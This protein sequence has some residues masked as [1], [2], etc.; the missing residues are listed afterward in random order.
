M[1]RPLAQTTRV[2]KIPGKRSGLF[3]KPAM[4]ELARQLQDALEIS[5]N[6]GGQV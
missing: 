6:Q 1:M 2:V 4:D 5:E 3:M